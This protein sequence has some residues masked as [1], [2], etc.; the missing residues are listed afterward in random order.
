MYLKIEGSLDTI[1][2]IFFMSQTK[3]ALKSYG[4]EY[5]VQIVLG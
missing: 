4:P 3:T 1:E 2:V 5:E